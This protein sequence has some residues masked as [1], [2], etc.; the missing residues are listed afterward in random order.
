[1]GVGKSFLGRLLAESL[2]FPFVDLDA[3][4]VARSGSSIPAFFHMHGE[5][6]FRQLE[7]ACLRAT[8][9]QPHVV[10]ATGGGT[11][12]FADNMPWMNEN[13]ITVF[14]DATTNT[15][16]E[17]LLPALHE[18]PL[19]NGLSEQ[20]LP[21]FIESKLAERLP[22]YRQTHFKLSVDEDGLA[23]VSQLTQYLRS[24]LGT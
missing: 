14:L 13:G 11:P 24:F 9:T 2:S 21:S 6:A 8:T 18:R 19:L 17:R 22:F 3:D 23:A 15:L 7:A 16:V 5:Y 4:I 12:C 10:V 1:M 20:E